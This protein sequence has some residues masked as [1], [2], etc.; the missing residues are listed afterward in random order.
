MRQLYLI[1]GTSGSGKTS[2]AWNIYDFGRGELEPVAADDF[3]VDENGDYK[4]DKERL[5]EVHE[6]C[7]LK[8]QSAMQKGSS[9]I[10]VHNTF[11]TMDERQAYHDLADLY[12]YQVIDMVVL[13]THGSQSV[14]DV[15]E[16]TLT[17][18]RDRLAETVKTI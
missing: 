12:N 11:T 17:A 16:K 13:N 4:F 14:H 5:T 3:M 18:Q 2:L 7:Q 15:P 9:R 8:V 6:K 1:G 10:F